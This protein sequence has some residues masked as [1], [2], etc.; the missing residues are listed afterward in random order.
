[1][2]E[3][4]WLRPTTNAKGH[5]T[6]YQ[7]AT[8]KHHDRDHRGRHEEKDDLFGVERRIGRGV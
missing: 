3:A 2:G 7:H 1:M 4:G 5:T 8:E 6:S